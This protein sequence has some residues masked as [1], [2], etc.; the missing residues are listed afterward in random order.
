MNTRK[1]MQV[2]A[3]KASNIVDRVEAEGRGGTPDEDRA[4]A[5]YLAELKELGNRMTP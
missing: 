4:I 2:L 1:R 3:D 5:G